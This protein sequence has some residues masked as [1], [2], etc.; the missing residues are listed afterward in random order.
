M[1]IASR[2]KMFYQQNVGAIEKLVF[3]IQLSKV[4]FTFHEL[5]A[6]YGKDKPNGQ[7]LPDDQLLSNAIFDER[8]SSKY[9]KGEC[10]LL[11]G[12]PRNNG[13]RHAAV[14]LN[15]DESTPIFAIADGEVVNDPHLFLEKT[16]ILEINHGFC[17]VRYGEIVPSLEMKANKHITKGEQIGTL[18]KQSGSSKLHFELYSNNRCFKN[19]DPMVQYDRRGD[20]VS[21]FPLLCK[22]FDKA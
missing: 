14:D 8:L 18:G 2:T 16:Y 6:Y 10:K 11:F 9:T 21:S 20:L 15:A 7:L 5:F 12:A 17:S 3:P 4:H 1:D 19:G 13:R 22:L